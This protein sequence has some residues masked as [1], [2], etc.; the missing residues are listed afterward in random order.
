M[1]GALL[2][3]SGKTTPD[4][5]F[6]FG[7]L[8]RFMSCH[9]K[10]Q[11]RV[12]NGVL[13]YLRGTTRLGVVF[14]GGEPLHGPPV[15]ANEGT[16]GDGAG[17]P[18]DALRVGRSAEGEAAA[19]DGLAGARPDGGQRVGPTWPEGGGGRSGEGGGAPVGSVD[20]KRGGEVA[21]RHG[22][23]SVPREHS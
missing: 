20:A 8:S 16:G 14:G 12:A 18:H 22:V 9:E 7:V 13:R 15:D 6:A 4:I 10:D 2:Y 21:T 3:L 11:M 1:V 17:Q 19:L 5:A 23:R